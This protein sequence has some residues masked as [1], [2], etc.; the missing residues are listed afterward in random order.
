[1][2]IVL[3]LLTLSVFIVVS[4]VIS[5]SDAIIAGAICLLITG[6]VVGC[7]L[8]DSFESA[9]NLDA[10]QEG[11]VAEHRSAIDLYSDKAVLHVDKAM[12][13]LKYQG[14]QEQMGNMIRELRTAVVEHNRALVSKRKYKANPFYSWLVILPDNDRLIH[15]VD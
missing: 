11:I 9:A 15:V 8:A 2:L 14:Y 7:S 4:A 6:T 5:N 1:M 3:G 10:I 13:D 12:A